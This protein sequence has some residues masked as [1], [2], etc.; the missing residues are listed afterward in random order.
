MPS[1]QKTS[2]VSVLSCCVVAFALSIITNAVAAADL[3]D[4]ARERHKAKPWYVKSIVLYDVNFFVT[5]ATLIVAALSIFY[6]YYAFVLIAPK[7]A[8]AVASH[9]LLLDHSEKSRLKL[10]DAKAKIGTDFDKFAQMAA[11]IS[12]CPS[13]SQG[14]TLGKF[15]P[16][17]MV[18]PFDRVVFAETSPVRTALGPIETQ[19]GWH[20]IYIQDRFIPEEK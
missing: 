9:I 13:K 3:D 18:P 16:G 11:Q 2:L 19:F 15:Q 14:G 6:L 8:T 17:T 12:E 4:V 5:P 10:V 20:L 1:L 7:P